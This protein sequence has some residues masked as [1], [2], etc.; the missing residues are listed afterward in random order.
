MTGKSIDAIREKGPQYFKIAGGISDTSEGGL[1]KII[2]DDTVDRG[3][4]VG[5]PKDHDR[6]YCVDLVKLRVFLY[7]TQP[8]IAEDLQLVTDNPTR[9]KFLARL[10]K[11]IGSPGVKDVV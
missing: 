4:W 2:V 3:W 5:N 11:E 9:R 6:E 1:E 8:K 7:S 10:E